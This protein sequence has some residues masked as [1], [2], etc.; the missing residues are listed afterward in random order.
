MGNKLQICIVRTLT[1]IKKKVYCVDFHEVSAKLTTRVSLLIF[2]E[3]SHNYW[4]TIVSVFC[5]IELAIDQWII[6]HNFGQKV[7]EYTETNN[8]HQKRNQS[9]LLIHLKFML[10]SY[11]SRPVGKLCIIWFIL[12]ILQ[13]QQQTDDIVLIILRSFIYVW[14]RTTPEVNWCS[15]VGRRI[16]M[17]A[18]SWHIIVH[19][20]PNI[21][22]GRASSRRDC[23]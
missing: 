13:M 22:T 11:L 3:F 20:A 4:F 10:M 19:L 12:C 23:K 17:L 7:T 18:E 6:K 14:L 16:Y 15:F 2:L 5:A 1:D 21:S 8:C 9:W